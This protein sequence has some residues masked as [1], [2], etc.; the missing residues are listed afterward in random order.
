MALSPAMDSA[1][2]GL[3]VTAFCAVKIVLPGGTVRLIDGSG[4]V[5]FGSETYTGLDPVYGTL[6]AIEQI[7]EEIA[8]SAP[9][10]RITLMPPDNAAIVALTNPMVQGSAVTIWVGV[11]DSSTGAVIGTPEAVFVGEID[12]STLISSSGNR[13]LEL[14]IASVWERLFADSEGARLN[15][16]FHKTVYP[17]ELGF[18]FVVEAK[19]DPYWGSDGPR[20]AATAT[21]SGSGVGFRGLPLAYDSMSIT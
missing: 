10:A 17:S 14:D 6:S 21:S 13:S 2:Q 9:R 19:D 12:T 3:V 11:V 8:T 20:P 1:L 5:T 7:N 16:F 18:D 4:M 15:G